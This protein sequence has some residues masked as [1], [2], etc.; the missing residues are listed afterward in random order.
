MLFPAPKPQGTTLHKPQ[1]R[2]RLYC[3]DSAPCAA[4]ARAEEESAESEQ[5]W[6]FTGGKGPLPLLLFVKML[7]E[8][9]CFHKI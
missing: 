3:K 6:H 9:F 1:A 7:I 2:R 8:E 5:L 4:R